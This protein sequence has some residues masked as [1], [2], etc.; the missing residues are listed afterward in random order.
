MNSLTF[1]IKTIII[2]KM[3]KTYWKHVREYKIILQKICKKC[4]G[5]ATNELNCNC[6]IEFKS[7]LLSKVDFYNFILTMVLL[8]PKK[9][10][11][12]SKSQLTSIQR[13]NESP[14]NII[15]MNHVDQS[16]LRFLAIPLPP[17][18]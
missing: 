8:G 10:L 4:K 17:P 6:K 14:S 1:E 15:F 11:I 12:T 9:I 2:R 18:A 16:Q 5:Y 7:I 3:L 13:L